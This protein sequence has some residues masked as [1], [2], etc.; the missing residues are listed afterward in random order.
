MIRIIVIIYTIC[1]IY[2]VYMISTVETI[3][4][5]WRGVRASPSPTRRTPGGDPLG[6]APARRVS[7]RVRRFCRKFCSGG[8]E[9]A[10]ALVEEGIMR[11][12]RRTVRPQ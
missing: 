5:V 2:E 12:G 11:P 7:Q 1:L 10:A 4:A 9:G 6:T 8:A 3:V